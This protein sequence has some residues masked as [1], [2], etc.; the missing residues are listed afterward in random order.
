V[1][2]PDGSR[3]GMPPRPAA[4]A[5]GGQPQRW[6]VLLPWLLDV[7]AATGLLRTA[8]R[9]AQPLPVMPWACACG[10]LPAPGADPNT[11][12][13]IGP[14]PAFDPENA[15]GADLEEPLIVASITSGGSE[16][17]APL[18]IE[19]FDRLYKAARLGREQLPSLVLT[20]AETL[21]IRHD[22]VL[23]PAPVLRRPARKETLP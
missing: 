6:F 19:G 16:L 21:A 5:Q 9:P 14:G 2:I 23:G 11:I 4:P 3:G 1:R 12:A 13:L 20:A 10:L 18:L 7:T 22:A 15:M 8:P 17:P